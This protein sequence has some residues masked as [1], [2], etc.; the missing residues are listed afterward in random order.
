LCQSPCAGVFTKERRADAEEFLHRVLNQNEQVDGW[1]YLHPDADVG[2]GESAVAMLRISISLR[3]A[4]H[5][6]MLREARCGRLATEYRNKLGWLKGNLYSRID[7]T[8]WAET[9]SGDDGERAIIKD[10]LNTRIAE[11]PPLW[12]PSTWIAEAKKKI[13]LTDVPAG[14][15]E[16]VLRELAPKPSLDVA[17]GEVKRVVNHMLD[18]FTDKPVAAFKAVIDSDLAIMPLLTRDA[19]VTIRDALQVPF[20]D[21]LWQFAESVST[22]ATLRGY[23]VATLKH[24]AESFIQRRGERKAGLFIDF[25][26]ALSPLAGDVAVR[27]M[28]LAEE[29]YGAEYLAKVDEVRTSILAVKWPLQLI[30]HLRTVVVASIQE[31][32]AD[33]VAG[34]LTNSP[35][36]KKS[37]KPD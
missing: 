23:V 13:K 28:F 3:A 18:E 12:V 22:D 2:I 7:T 25:L 34:R 29:V 26:A 32:V 31:S 11:R 19:V 8:D 10:L 35:L 37:M 6:D 33:L 36:F 9:D 4:E 24:A 20:D 5:Y 27:L 16:Q 14:E 21:R 17:L 1:V 30:A 15:L